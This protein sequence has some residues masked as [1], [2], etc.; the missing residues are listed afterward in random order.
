MA[1]KA[2]LPVLALAGAGFGWQHKTDAEVRDALRS[3]EFSLV[4]DASKALEQHWSAVEEAIPTAL[5]VDCP[6]SPSL[7]ADLDVVS[8]PAIRLYRQDG[9]KHYF[10]GPR[11]ASEI[12]AFVRRMLR[13]AVTLLDKESAESF[14][15]VDDVVLIAHAIESETNLRE[16]FA[17]MAERYRDR[18]TFG[19]TTVDEAPGRVG[20]YNNADGAYHMTSE[21][22]EVGAMESL[23]RG[24]AS[25]LVPRLTRRNE[26]EHLSTGKS[27]AYFFSKDEG[28]LDAWTSAVKPLAR[29]Y[30]EYITFVTVDTGEYPEMPALFG[31]RAGASEGF[32]LQN[33]SVG[34]AFPFK[35]GKITVEA[36]DQHI[37]DISQGNADAWQVGSPAPEEEEQEEVPA[38]AGEEVQQQKVSQ[39][40]EGKAEDEETRESN[41]AA[42]HDEL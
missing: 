10:R 5:S 23:L 25:Q 12:A 26:A 6:A 38:Q 9:T 15:D 13:P 20:C 22:D 2:L 42:A 31:L 1:F 28:N 3:N 17:A 33:P 4:A 35:G 37:L 36:V 19:L 41:A 16:R 29:K 30:H 27:L 11:K 39:E 8:F 14:R 40:E 32:A 18:H 21:L 24:C 7:C 34:L